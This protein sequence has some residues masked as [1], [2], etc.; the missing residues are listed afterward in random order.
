M[1]PNLFPLLCCLFLFVTTGW[2][3]I[4]NTGTVYL[5]EKN[6]YSSLYSF[7]NSDTG[8]FY[9]DGQAYFLKDFT[10]DGTFDFIADSAT[11]HFAGSKTQNLTGN[12][13]AYFNRLI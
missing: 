9:N 2:A 4:V 1:K 11:V 8:E 3:Q 5:G 10:N 7:T 6:L 13:E 12:Q